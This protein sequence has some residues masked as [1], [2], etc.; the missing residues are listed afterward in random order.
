[1]SAQP[2]ARQS[3]ADVRREDVIEAL[4]GHV[5][6]RPERLTPAL[7]M[8][9]STVTEPSVDSTNFE[10]RRDAKRR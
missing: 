3:A 7:E 5:E 6:E 8:R 4:L 2:L 10:P 1:L 9:A